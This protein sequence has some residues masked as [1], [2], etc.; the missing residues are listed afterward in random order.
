MLIDYRL[1]NAQFALQPHSLH[2]EILLNIRCFSSH[3]LAP[4]SLSRCRS[5]T[6]QPPPDAAHFNARHPCFCERRTSPHK[7]STTLKFPPSLGHHHPSNNLSSSSHAPYYFSS[8]LAHSI[9]SVN[10]ARVSHT[11]TAAGTMVSAACAV[12]QG[13]HGAG[14]VVVPT[15]GD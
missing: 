12:G 14:E 4:L 15:V 10:Q 7:R 8:N 2:L 6:H 1:R 3:S 9:R 13:V 11:A 5:T